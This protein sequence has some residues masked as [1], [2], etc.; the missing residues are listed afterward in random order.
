MLETPVCSTL[1]P[2]PSSQRSAS[3]NPCNAVAWSGGYCTRPACNRSGGRQ[4]LRAS[5]AF[6]TSVRLYRRR[7]T[8][9]E[10]ARASSLVGQYS[11][12]GGV[13]TRRNRKAYRGGWRA[14]LYLH[15]Y[16]QTISVDVHDSTLGSI[17]KLSGFF[18]PFPIRQRKTSDA[19]Q[20]A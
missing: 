12:R 9:E 14:Y 1:L 16:A 7:E 4:D 19:S 17:Q 20:Q 6:Q 8:Y 5:V 15:V 2:C 13:T 11:G 18:G 3:G 10:A